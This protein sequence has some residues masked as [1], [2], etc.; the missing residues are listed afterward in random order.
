MS[1]SHPQVSTS[2]YANMPSRVSEAQLW[3]SYP[4][5]FSTTKE[6]LAPEDLIFDSRELVRLVT[7][8]KNKKERYFERG[9]DGLCVRARHLWLS[10]Q[11]YTLIAPSTHYWPG[12]S[13]HLFSGNTVPAPQSQI[14]LAG[15]SPNARVHNRYIFL[16]KGYTFQLKRVRSRVT[17][18]SEVS[19]LR[20]Y[21]G[22]TL[23]PNTTPLHI[24]KRKSTQSK[25]SPT[26]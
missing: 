9:L 17:S 21:S 4:E 16:I 11:R 8:N 25:S 5:F 1:D 14:T 22:I 15:C 26:R 3:P 23:T 18:S 6:K 10:L 24:K 19:Q 20:G 7:Q 2:L 12:H 13:S